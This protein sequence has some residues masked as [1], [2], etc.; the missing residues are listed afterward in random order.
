MTTKR[1][2]K[3]GERVLILDVQSGLLSI[4]KKGRV[5]RLKKGGE[6]VRAE[7]LA[8]LY[9]QVRIQHN[10]KRLHVAASRL[11]WQHFFGNIEGG[12]CINHINGK[13]LDNRPENLE[14]VTYSEN[15]KH[16]YRTGLKEQYGQK[17]PNCRL[18]D[19][20]VVDIRERYFQ[21]EASQSEL[22][23]EYGVSQA[24]ISKL[25]RGKRRLRQ[26]GP[27]SID[28]QKKKARGFYPREYPDSWRVP[29]VSG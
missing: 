29:V 1:K 18:T 15:I 7:S 10:R 24:T 20:V 25:V 23:K 2:H 21:E 8:R 12:L 17:N 11:V 28:N 26:G 19:E 3:L 13:K 27:L 5:W 14:L 22:A 9:Y 4:D 6:R 16:A